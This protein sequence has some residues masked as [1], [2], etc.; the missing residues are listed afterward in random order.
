MVRCGLHP[1][2]L[3]VST[4]FLK[5]IFHDESNIHPAYVPVVRNSCLEGNIKGI[6]VPVGWNSCLEGNIKGIYVPVGW[7]S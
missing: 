7:N 1:Y 6:Y 5:M 4:S 2:S 3:H